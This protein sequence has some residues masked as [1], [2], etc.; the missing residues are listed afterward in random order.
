MTTGRPGQPREIVNLASDV[1]DARGYVEDRDF[2]RALILGPAVLTFIENV[3]FVNSSFAGDPDSL[4][5]EVPQGRRIQGVVALRNVRFQDCRFEN[6]A[7]IGTPEVV[8]R[9]RKEISV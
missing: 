9:L 1:I 8:A 3:R 4:F 6:I 5:I 2:E 7:F